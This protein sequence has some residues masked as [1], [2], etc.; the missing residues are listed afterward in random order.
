MGWETLLYN[1]GRQTTALGQIQST[2][3]ALHIFKYLK[4]I[5]NAVIFC[6]CENWVEFSVD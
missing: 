1:R 4:K 2:K 6:K 5:Q 3:N